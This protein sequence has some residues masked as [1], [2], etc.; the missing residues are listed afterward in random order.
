V[1]DTTNT[2]VE[3]RQR[4]LE[5]GLMLPIWTDGS[6]LPHWTNG[7]GEAGMRWSTTVA[8]ARLAESVGFDSLWVPDHF[9]MDEQV[10]APAAEGW[11]AATDAVDPP[12]AFW[13]A[14]SILA[15]LAVATTIPKLGTLV[16]CAG[17]RN[18]ALLA[19]IADTVDEMS[20]GRVILGIGAGDHW[21]EHERY[22]LS[23]EQP[24]GRFEEA[25]QI[26]APLLR[27]G[28]VDFDG[29]HHHAR[30]AVLMPRGPRPN[31]PPILIGAL[32]TGPRM[33]RLVAQYADLW[34][35]WFVFDDADPGDD[36]ELAL[37][38]VSDACELHGRDPATLGRTL[39]LSIGL[40]GAPA[41]GG[42]LAGPPPAI[43]D[44]LR[45][46]AELGVQHVQVVLAPSGQPGIEAFAEV[47][48]LLDTG[49]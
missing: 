13:E 2:V 34:N 35:G 42:S 24:V 46:F 16:A 27:D 17:Y 48:D 37:A 38:R 22:G 26:I 6:C 32:G 4:P 1:S 49:R 28:R 12:T 20:D 31:G 41:H 5:V 3:V 47:L 30:G 25:L 23:W 10:E 15:G 40:N 14:W 9:A 36:I 33:L 44:R 8:N 43:A 11:P 7:H 45:R 29:R 39:G 18:P 19:K 21:G